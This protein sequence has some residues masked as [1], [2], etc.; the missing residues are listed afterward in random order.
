MKK[1]I[2]EIVK[3][4]SGATD[5]AIACMVDSGDFS[6]ICK[7]DLINII[8]DINGYFRVMKPYLKDDFTSAI[9]GISSITEEDDINTI[10]SALLYVYFTIDIIDDYN[11]DRKEL[12]TILDKYPALLI[13]G[14]AI[15]IIKFRSHLSTDQI[16]K[17]IETG[18]FNELSK[19]TIF[20]ISNDISAVLKSIKIIFS[21][22]FITDAINRI[23]DYVDEKEAAALLCYLFD[24]IDKK[25]FVTHPSC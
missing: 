5:E 17:M 10:N 8:K 23:N 20:I 13:Y 1:V 3:K 9:D 6:S 22:T 15:K 24:V 25:Y 21:N 19:D 4:H 2:N 14:I 7:N 16:I 11:K 12:M 18:S